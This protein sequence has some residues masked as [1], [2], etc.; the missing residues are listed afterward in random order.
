M[1]QW[2]QDATVGTWYRF[3]CFCCQEWCLYNAFV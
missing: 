1:F 2:L 3:C